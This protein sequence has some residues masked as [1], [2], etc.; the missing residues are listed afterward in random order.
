MPKVGSKSF[1]YTKKGKEMAKKE[2]M[3]SKMPMMKRKEMTKMMKKKK[4]EESK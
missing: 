2:V 4:E 1:P 3:K